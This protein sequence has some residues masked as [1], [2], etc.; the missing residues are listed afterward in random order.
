MDTPTVSAAI[1]TEPHSR[2]LMLKVTLINVFLT[3]VTVWIHYEALHIMADRLLNLINRRRIH[4][5][6]GVIGALLAHVI[7]IWLYGIVYFLVLRHGGF[8]SLNGSDGNLLDCVYFS[9]SNY[10]SL[11]MGDIQP[12]GMVRFIAGLEALTGLVLITWTASFLF[13]EM[14]K[15]W[16]RSGG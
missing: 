15:I 8:G 12:V 1:S 5:I 2:P 4:L 13:L 14:Q 16:G 3:V 7:E 10:T 9:L 6:L 11:G